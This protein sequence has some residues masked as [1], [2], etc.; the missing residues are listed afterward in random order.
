M[1][2]EKFFKIL[3]KIQDFRSLVY[4]VFFT[5]ASGKKMNCPAASRGVSLK[6]KFILTQQAA[7]NYT[8]K[9]IKKSKKHK[10]MRSIK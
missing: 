8:L 3:K 1:S 4:T 2:T 9:E 10:K 6:V 7:R 5:S